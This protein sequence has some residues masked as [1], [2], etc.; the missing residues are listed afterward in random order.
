MKPGI[1]TLVSALVVGSLLA[2]PSPA[3]AIPQNLSI[4]VE[5]RGYD[6]FSMMR[7]QAAVLAQEAV[8]KAFQRNADTTEVSV[9]VS[10]DRNGQIAP[11]LS[12]QITRAQWE[13]N[14]SIFAAAR[15][16]DGSEQLLGFLDPPSSLPSTTSQQRPSASPSPFPPAPQPFPS[17]D[18]D[19]SGYRDD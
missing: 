13:Q 8:A 7:Q 19:I 3:W 15:Y 10:G 17:S 9:M 16:F 1:R 2:V 18:D 4:I 6:S 11:L 5:S 14:A 12:A